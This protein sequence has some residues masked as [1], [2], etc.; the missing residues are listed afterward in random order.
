MDKHIVLNAVTWINKLLKLSE[1]E[2]CSQTIRRQCT[3]RIPSRI[4]GSWS[5][6]HNILVEDYFHSGILHLAKQ[7]FKS[8]RVHFQTWKNSKMYFQKATLGCASLTQGNNQSGKH[9][10]GNNKRIERRIVLLTGNCDWTAMQL[11]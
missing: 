1:K 11:V 10:W 2:V 3:I 9:D 8:E 7:T 6:D 5:N 4:T